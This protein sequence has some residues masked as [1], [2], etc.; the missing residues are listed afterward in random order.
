LPIFDLLTQAQTA[1]PALAGVKYVSENWVR[2]H[3]RLALCR[4]GAD[5]LA[6]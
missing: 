2:R 6:C 1:L 5:A 4:L 3:K